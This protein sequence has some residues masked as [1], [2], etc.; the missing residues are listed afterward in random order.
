MTH[1]ETDRTTP[2]E[3]EPSGSTN[4]P[5]GTSAGHQAGV[6]TAL[7]QFASRVKA[8]RYQEPKRPHWRR[9][10]GKIKGPSR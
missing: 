1:D 3:A 7:Q 2:I 8:G 10:R 4:P 6:R 5:S 9:A